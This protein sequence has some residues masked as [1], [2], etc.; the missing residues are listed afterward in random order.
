MRPRPQYPDQRWLLP[1]SPP[2]TRPV[3][4]A[5]L[6]SFPCCQLTLKT[7]KSTL[8]CQGRIAQNICFHTLHGQLTGESVRRGEG[9]VSMEQLPRGFLPLQGTGWGWGA[10]E[11]RG[12]HRHRGRPDSPERLTA[13]AEARELPTTAISSHRAGRPRAGRREG[14]G[15]AAASVPRPWRASWG[16][17]SG[18]ADRLCGWSSGRRAAWVAWCG[19]PR[20]FSP[21]S[22]KPAPA[23]SPDAKFSSWA[24]VPVLS[25]SWR[26]PW[27]ERRRPGLAGGRTGPLRFPPVRARA[28]RGQRCDCR[29]GAGAGPYCL[30]YHL[31]PRFFWRYLREILQILAKRPC[32]A[33][34]LWR[35]TGGS[36][37][38]A[39]C[40]PGRTW[41]SP[42]LRSCRSC[43]RLI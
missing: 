28:K 42:T 21:N 14:R 5:A 10:G 1:S 8:F 15:G 39:V 41:R 11:G 17:W 32:G 2:T 35:G 19:T 3:N 36:G 20:W 16:S 29:E 23:L 33:R 7:T 34:S 26:P 30:F 13:T 12:R 22:W 31:L 18:G 43:W 6:H 9:A 24:P 27:G 4:A 38:N 40:V 25:G 37:R